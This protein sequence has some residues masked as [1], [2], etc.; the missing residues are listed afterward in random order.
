MSDA[1]L[2]APPVKANPFHE[3]EVLWVRHW[4]DQLFSFGVKR[5]EDFR[6]RSGEFVMI[7]LPGADG[8][9]PILRAYSIA[10]PFWAE[11]LEFFSIKVEDGPLTSRLQKIVAGDSVLMGKKPTGTLVLDALTGGERLWLIGTGTGLA[12][13]LSVA[14]DPETYS[15]FRQVIVCHTVRN[16]ADLAYRDFFSHEIHDDPLIGDEAKAQLTYYP[17]VTRE[18]FETPGRITDRIK[19]GDLFADLQLPIG[20][21]PNSDRVMLCGSM[22]MIKE[23]G[24]LLE[25]HGLKEGSNAE[26]GD[27]VLERAFVG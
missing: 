8:G 25:S 11:E 18:R 10:S 9:K 5:P 13:W 2:A 23:T 16:V 17:T 1:S 14:R 12:P 27:Y 19:S 7:G 22:A 20:F 21:S 4:N 26:P 15:R 3:L 24:E 6:F